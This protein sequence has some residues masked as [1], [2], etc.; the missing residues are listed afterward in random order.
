[1][2]QSEKAAYLI[3]KWTAMEYLISHL[4]YNLS[5]QKSLLGKCSYMYQAK[6]CD[7]WNIQSYTKESFA[8]LFYT[9]HRIYSGQDN[10]YSLR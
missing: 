3:K 4:I 7:L 5:I 9:I 2:L 6:R 1:M 10:Q 8:Q